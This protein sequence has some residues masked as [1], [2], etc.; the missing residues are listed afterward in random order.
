MRLH[1]CSSVLTHVSL[2][3]CHVSLRVCVDAPSYISHVS[4]RTFTHASH[5]PLRVFIKASQKVTCN[6]I[7]VATSFPRLHP[8]SLLCLHTCLHK[9]LQICNLRC[10]RST[11][12]GPVDSAPSAPPTRLGPLGSDPQFGSAPSV[13]PTR[14]G[15]LGSASRIGPPRLGPLCSANSGRTTRLGAL[16]SAPPP[17]GHLGSALA[18]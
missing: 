13:R 14:I 4:S 2:H 7:T 8:C 12:L 16:H 17:L 3:T 9:C 6:I 15:H 18:A 5:A 1:M 10:P 11:R